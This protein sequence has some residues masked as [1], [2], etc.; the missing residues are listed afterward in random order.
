MLAWAN[1]LQDGKPLAGVE[2]T[3]FPGDVR[4]TTGDDGTARMSLQTR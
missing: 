4:A 3:L 1:A 2:L